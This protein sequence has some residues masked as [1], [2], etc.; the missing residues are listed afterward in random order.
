MKLNKEE[1]INLVILC[2]R[3]NDSLLAV[4]EIQN[5]PKQKSFLITTERQRE[6]I[7]TFFT[8]Q[9]I[10]NYEFDNSKKIYRNIGLEMLFLHIFE[11]VQELSI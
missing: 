9:I 10:I 4:Y 5:N 8:D 3:D 1:E 7:K 2:S 6:K 11:V